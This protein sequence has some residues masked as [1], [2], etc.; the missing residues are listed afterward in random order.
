[1][2]EVVVVTMGGRLVV[3]LPVDFFPDALVLVDEPGG[4]ET[5]EDLPCGC[6]TTM[7]IKTRTTMR[8]TA[9]SV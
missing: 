6:S 4:V 1:V 2:V 7:P 9:R 3:V 5:T 8:P